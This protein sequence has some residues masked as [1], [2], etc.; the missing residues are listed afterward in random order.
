[1]RSTLNCCQTR[2]KKCRLR[3]LTDPKSFGVLK[4]TALLSTGEALSYVTA[5][6]KQIECA[7]NCVSNDDSS[8]H[9]SNDDVKICCIICGR[10]LASMQTKER[11]DGSCF[12]NLH[13]R[14]TNWKIYVFCNGRS[15]CRA[16]LHIL[17]EIDH[18]KYTRG[19]KLF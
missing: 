3:F 1:M 19:R 18:R 16:G 6:H 15:V 2:R 10:F 5:R 11:P 12:F 13:K 7:S 9:V 4:L 14:S 17:T 8:D